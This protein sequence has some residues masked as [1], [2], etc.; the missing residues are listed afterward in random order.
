MKIQIINLLCI[1]I[2]L[3]FLNGCDKST[4]YEDEITVELK[5]SQKILSIGE[6]LRGTFSVTNNTEEKKLFHFSTSCQFGWILSLNGITLASTGTA[7]YTS[8][9]ELQLL[10]G[11]SKKF[12]IKYFL[13][14]KDGNDLLL[15]KYEVEAF[16]VN[17]EHKVS[18]DFQIY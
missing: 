13:V 10:A 2:G 9:T 14:D 1:F 17:T 16:L 8:P 3:I 4:N 15:G 11:E 12:E 6:T 7:C 18:T 5:I